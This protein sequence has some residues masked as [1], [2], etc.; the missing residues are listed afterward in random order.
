[1]RWRVITLTDWGMSLSACS[2]LPS[3]SARA[4]Y[5][6]VPSVVALRSASAVTVTG[7][8]VVLPS[9]P[10][11]AG[12]PMLE[13]RSAYAPPAPPAAS[14]PEPA[15]SRAKP[16]ATACWPC[17]PGERLPCA[18]AGGIVMLTPAEAAK[19]DRASSSGP[20]AML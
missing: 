20:G 10:V 3:V 8:S 4:V 6:R 9:A 1:M 12:P 13:R 15:S 14:R 11:S 19:L 18:R 5:E 17:R 7:A 2:P 16:S